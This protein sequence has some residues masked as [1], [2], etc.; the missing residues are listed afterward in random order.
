[1]ISFHPEEDVYLVNSDKDDDETTVMPTERQLDYNDYSDGGCVIAVGGN[2]LSRGLTLEGLCVSYFVRET[3]IYDSLTQMGRWFG[4]RPGY[5]DLVRLY[6]SPNLLEW[7]MWLVDVESDLRADIE[8]YDIEDKGPLDLA[9]RV[10]KHVRTAPGE[11]QLSPTRA[12]AMQYAEEWSGGLDGMTP[13]TKNFYLDDTLILRRNLERASDFF[14]KLSDEYGA[15][16]LLEK[17]AKNSYL[18]K[19]IIDYDTII[20]FISEQGFPSL[21]SWKLIEIVPYI[22]S[23]VEGDEARTWSVCFVNNSNGTSQ[24]IPGSN[25]QD[26]GLSIAPNIRNRL[27]GKTSIDELTT[28]T[29]IGMDM[30]GYPSEYTGLEGRA[31]AK[32]HRNTDHPLLLIY[33][34]DKDSKP[35]SER[36]YKRPLQALFEGYG[37]KQHVVGLCTVFPYSESAESD[38]L[39]SFYH[40][41]GVDPVITGD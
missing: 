29:H 27:I 40:A 26:T 3:K 19:S 2:I 10:L 8:R 41:R 5:S 33:I 1:M 32:D 23:R 17:G 21:G 31:K 9:V 36:S 22:L 20:D 25:N 35:D 13:M 16:T 34:I 14:A 12:L 15:P 7:F 28:S 37:N 30:D 6:L 11:V 18:W 24:S 4:F 38:E 39:R